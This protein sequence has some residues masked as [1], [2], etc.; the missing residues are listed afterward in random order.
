VTNGPATLKK[1]NAI[2]GTK[3]KHIS[4]GATVS[5]MRTSKF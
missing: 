2:A 4:H 3:S 5:P 1:Q